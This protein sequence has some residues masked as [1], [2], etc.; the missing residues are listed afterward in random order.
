[1][2]LFD[3]CPTRN[4]Q[5]NGAAAAAG[6]MRV[7]WTP[8]AGEV[9]E[10]LYADIFHNDAAAPSGAWL[11]TDGV[12]LIQFG[13]GAALAS[14][15]RRSLYYADFPPRLYLDHRCTLSWVVGAGATAGAV[16]TMNVIGRCLRGSY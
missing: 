7:D 11:F 14:G 10:I 13:N 15:V 8:A 2:K 6:V 1:M 5:V 16:T 12:T 9:W 4:Y 3:S